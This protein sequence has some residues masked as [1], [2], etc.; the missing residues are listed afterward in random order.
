M[1]RDTSRTRAH[2]RSAT[3]E[4]AS[5]PKGKRGGARKGAGRP[6]TAQERRAA[7]QGVV[8]RAGPPPAD[9]LGRV[10]WAQGIS[11]DMLVLY[12]RGQIPKEHVQEARSSA[13]TIA[14][15]VPAERVYQA[16]RTITDDEDRADDT[17]QNVEL[18]HAPQESPAPLSGTPR[19]GPRSR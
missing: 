10:A 15:L 2:A 13:R 19:R 8:D 14:A 4:T 7:L 5:A 12:L 1:V 16:E 3:E 17:A 6:S 11:S 18:T 9:P